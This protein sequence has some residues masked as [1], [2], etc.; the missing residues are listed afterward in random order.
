MDKKKVQKM[1]RDYLE[2]EDGKE[3]QFLVK[4]VLV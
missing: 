1:Y 3:A 4:G 2:N